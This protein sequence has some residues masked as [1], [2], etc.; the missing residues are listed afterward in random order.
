MVL[1]SRHR[2]KLRR[3]PTCQK[4][5][6]IWRTASGAVSATFRVLLSLFESPAVDPPTILVRSFIVLTEPGFPIL[7]K[8]S[9]VSFAGA[10]PVP[11]LEIL[12][13]LAPMDEAV[14]PRRL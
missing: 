2:R 13:A 12:L 7:S 10:A 3:T 8:F 6:I 9:A 1:S 5:G 14:A 11:P 4:S